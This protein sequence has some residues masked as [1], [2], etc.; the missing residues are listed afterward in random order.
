[1]GL[2]AA[3]AHDETR[4]GSVNDRLSST[5]NQSHLQRES[6]ALLFNPKKDAPGI[7]RSAQLPE[8]SIGDFSDS[9]QPVSAREKV[10]PAARE[11]MRV[12]YNDGANPL[13]S[14]NPDACVQSDLGNCYLM[15][16]M[17]S[18]A[19]TNPQLIK[20]MISV[21][22]DGSYLVKFP[23]GR[24]EGYRVDKPTHVP[25]ENA[26]N[27]WPYVLSRAFGE[28]RKSLD[29]ALANMDAEEITSGGEKPYHD[30]MSVLT[31]S[32]YRSIL[33][34]EADL[35]QIH[36]FMMNA[37]FY[38]KMPITCG[39]G[40]CLDNLSAEE[41]TVLEHRNIHPYHAYS[42]V[43]YNPRAQQIKL[44]NPWGNYAFV[45]IEEFKKY[46]VGLGSAE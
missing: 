33:N 26:D 10:T 31:G 21:N 18:L 14:I 34:S 42:V 35:G 39:T 29:P 30:E 32:N 25:P 41:K 45:S 43:D 23:G 37:F 19:K 40:G 20:D 17:A 46:F 7:G 12:L 28:Y 16:T 11:A 3:R 5:E 22:P 24:P 38:R 36:D 8:L 27:I 13:A 1:M 9:V 4:A 15:S 6:L 2:E 44:R